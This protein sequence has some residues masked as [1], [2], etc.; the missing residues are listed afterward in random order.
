M[1]LLEGAEDAVAFASGM[2]AV[3]AVLLTLLQQGDHLLVARGLYGCSH[4][5]VTEQLPRFGIEFTEVDF[6]QL[7]QVVEAIRPNTRLVLLE[8]PVNPHLQVFDLDRIALLAR[9]HELLSVVDNTFMTPL[10]QR[11]LSHGIDVVLHSATKYLN[12]HGDVIAGVVCGQAEL[13][14]RLRGEIRKD[15]GA[16]LSPH[17]A[18]LILRGLKTL[19]VRLERHC[20]NALAVAQFLQ[21]HPGVERVFYP[22]LAGHA[23]SELIGQ[24]MAAGGGVVA[25]ELKGD[26]ADALAFADGLKL[27]TLAVSLGDA[28]S[29]VQHPASM[30]HSPYEPEARR[31][32]GI[33]DTLVRLAIGL[34]HVDDLLADLAQALEPNRVS[35]GAPPAGEVR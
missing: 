28:E 11:P 30:T 21:A 19:A 23:G 7:D 13:M 31:R 3:S 1:A 5:L 18:W 17:D 2:A 15:F 34:E 33:S 6:S 25:L 20:A 8:T 29:L 24:Q 14:A 12:G 35:S 10:L 16:V 32:A 22:G 27:F 4:S 9:Q 26:Y